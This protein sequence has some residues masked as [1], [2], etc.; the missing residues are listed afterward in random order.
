[1]T[2]AADAQHPSARIVLRRETADLHA[3]LDALL[4]RT[5]FDDREAYADF[6]TRQAGPLFAIE[7]ALEHAAIAATLG[8]WPRRRRTEAMRADCAALGT[9][10]VVGA[11]ARDSIAVMAFADTDAMFGALYVLEGSRLGA[12]FLV[13]HARASKDETVRAATAYLG[14]GEGTPFWSTFLEALRQRETKGLD[15]TALVQGAR[16]AFASFIAS[17]RRAPAEAATSV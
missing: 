8:D 4:S 15:Q 9:H 2:T 3:D 1:M 16:D 11:G 6:L 14:H 17:A 10:A 7:S 13:R 12:K 5:D